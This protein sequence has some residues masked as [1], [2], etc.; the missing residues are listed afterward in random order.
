M[1]RNALGPRK[2]LTEKEA[3]DIYFRVRKERK[4]N[5]R[6]NLGNG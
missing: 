5:E 1:G 6:K 4:D 3:W 2:V